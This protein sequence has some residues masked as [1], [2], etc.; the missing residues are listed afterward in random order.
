[1]LFLRLAILC[2]LLC[3]RPGAAH[4]TVRYPQAESPDDPRTSFPLQVL[5]LA[6][7]KSGQHVTLS[8][9][10]QRMQQ[11]RALASLASGDIDLVWSAATPARNLA[12]RRV[13]VPLDDGL[14]GWRVALVRPALRARVAG[15]RS[16]ADLRSLRACLGHDWPDRD[17]FAANGL[18]VVTAAGYETLFSLL[19]RG[20]CDYFP[21]AV[22]EAWPELRAHPRSAIMVAEPTLLRYQLGLYFFV[23][24]GNVVL[25]D[26][27]EAGMQA[28]LQDGSLQRLRTA[29]FGT[30]QAYVAANR[31]H[32]IVLDQP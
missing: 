29:H 27:L 31:D 20:A 12:L 9:S 6:L 17:I 24:A 3:C 21:R 28:A 10:A 26:A 19:E 4:P 22:T 7:A 11:G 1:M 16:L 13:S 15:A 14:L 18:P 25:A 23:N 8:P 5:A 32:A 30:A 2:F